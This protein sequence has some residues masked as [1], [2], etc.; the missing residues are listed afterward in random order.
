MLEGSQAVGPGGGIHE[1]VLYWRGPA[2]GGTMTESRISRRQVLA[3]GLGGAA[4]FGLAAMGGLRSSGAETVRR[5]AKV[6]AAGSDL[7]AVEH[8]VFL[9]MENRSFDHLFGT[10]SGVR[11]F[12]DHSSGN[13]GVF[14]QSWPGGASS[15]LLPFHLNTKNS[16]AE[17]T[18]D[19]THNWLPQHQCWNNG[20]MDSFVSTHTSVEGP[21]GVLTMGYYKKSDIPFL[22]DLANKFTI[23]DGYHCSVLGPTHPNRLFH[24][25]G[26]NDPDGVAGGPILVTNSSPTKK[27]TTSWS[28][29]PEA[30]N[31][32]SVS[33]RVYNP[34]GSSYDIT[35]NNSMLLNS[36]PLQ[37]FTQYQ[38]PASTLYQNA[39][40]YY[41]PN[42]TNALS[43]P[44]GPDDFG[45]DVG[46]GQLPAVSWIIP[47]VG[48]D[49]HPPA[50]PV[51]GE[52]YIQQVLNTLVANPAVWAKT[53]LF[54]SWDENDGFFDHVA[55]PVA[56]S[57]TAGEYLT[58]TLPPD[59]NGVAGPIG[60]GVRVPML[61][62][63]PFSVGGWVC[64][65]TFDHTS[66]MR[67]LETRFGVTAPNI[68]SWR[69]GVTGDLTA[70]LPVL[71]N[72][73]TKVP[74]LPVVSPSTTI[75]PI[76]TECVAPQLIELNVPQ[77][78]YAIKKHQK[79]PT[80]KAGTRPHTPN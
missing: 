66:Q 25:S 60:L 23:G 53:V 20:A 43:N 26:T 38:N 9:M 72:P 45:H 77:G 39:F 48:F 52:W 69:R 36:N 37:Y 22:Y 11:G 5:A 78:P 73:V 57:G 54:I 28:T 27:F 30:L 41:G 64:S 8:V 13:D 44:N 29:M 46:T 19:L 68:S 55:L 75:A 62:V 70:T 16:M 50:P 10:M 42:V 24:M 17:C 14:A 12:D 15:T 71:D 32:A 4:A 2:Q 40:S 31:A 6:K 3:G 79:M 80:Q 1:A 59:A 76:S 33:W 63:S 67:F 18:F 51:L 56:P 49:Q 65:E 35:S 74:R 61:V 7:G 47:P 58:G 21:N 34:S